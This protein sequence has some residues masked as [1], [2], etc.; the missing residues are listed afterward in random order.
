VRQQTPNLQTLR[1]LEMIQVSKPFLILPYLMPG[2]DSSS[3]PKQS[4]SLETSTS[5]QPLKSPAGRAARTPRRAGTHQVRLEAL[6]DSLGPLGPLGDNA[7]TPQADLPP[8]PP[9]KEQVVTHNI[10]QPIAPSQSSMNRSILDSVDLNDDTE[11]PS[12]PRIPPPVQ[13]SQGAPVRRDTQPSVSIEQAAKPSFDITVGDPHKVGD[14]TSSHIVYLVRTKVGISD[15]PGKI[16]ANASRLH[17]RPIDKPNSQLLEDTGTSYGCTT[18]Y[19][20]TT[21]A[22]LFHHRQRSKPLDDLTPT[23]WNH[24][25]LLWNECSTR[26]QPIL[27]FNMTAI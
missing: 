11:P 20:Q 8:A 19:M 3:K 24:E 15:L 1:F 6:D 13:P 10:R 14:L 12:G 18:H 2:E 21:Q 16:L 27:R 9:Q 23:S 17:P 5:R 4:Q 25:E 26:P 22:L 7:P